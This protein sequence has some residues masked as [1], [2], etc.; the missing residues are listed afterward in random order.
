LVASPRLHFDLDSPDPVARTPRGT[1][2]FDTHS[3]TLTKDENLTLSVSGTTRK[4]YVKWRIEMDTV[5][6]NGR[7]V[8]GVTH[9][10]KPFQVT[11]R[12]SGARAYSPNFCL[13]IDRGSV[14]PTR[15]RSPFC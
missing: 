5:I 15:F 12:R 3:I 8:I 4:R 7:R 1:P 6:D 13:S 9:D 14:V 2:Y 10:G 11:A